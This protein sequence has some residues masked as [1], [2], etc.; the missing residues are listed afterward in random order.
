MD[1]RVSY[2]HSLASAPDAFIGHTKMKKLIGVAPLIFASAMAVSAPKNCYID[3]AEG[4]AL[5]QSQAREAADGKQL[6]AVLTELLA[7]NEKATGPGPIGPQLSRQDRSRFQQLANK[8]VELRLKAAEES[9]RQRDIDVVFRLA[10]IAERTH[11]KRFQ[12]NDPAQQPEQFPQTVL[13][14][15][16]EEHAAGVLA[17][18]HQAASCT[19]DE[20][21]S[22]AQEASKELIGDDQQL[23]VNLDDYLVSMELVKEMNQVSELIYKSRIAVAGAAASTDDPDAVMSKPLRD[24]TQQHRV[25]EKTA[26]MIHM[27]AAI[28]GT[29]L[30]EAQKRFAK[31]QQSQQVNPADQ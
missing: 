14:V 31:D 20:S 10:S 11:L 7:I 19:I 5:R 22:G 12:Y 15:L 2:E 4:A 30:S 16:E 29:Y 1:Y 6:Q 13:G 23:K 25:S 28:D 21:L 24:A 8:T 9:A 3:D 18:P 26:S 27:W 17:T